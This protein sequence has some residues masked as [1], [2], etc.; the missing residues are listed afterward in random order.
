MEFKFKKSLIDIQR[1]RKVL[2]KHVNVESVV[3]NKHKMYIEFRLKNNM[4][5]TVF[6]CYNKIE[7]ILGPE[8]NF[9]YYQKTGYNNI[10]IIPTEYFTLSIDQLSILIENR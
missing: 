5:Y 8:L 6:M 7:Y 1:L 4:V 10:N 9:K 3:F 2:R